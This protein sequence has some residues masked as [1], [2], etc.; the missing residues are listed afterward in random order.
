MDAVAGCCS[1]VVTTLSGT[2]YDDL[3]AENLTDLQVPL[4]IF[5]GEKKSAGNRKICIAVANPPWT[6]YFHLS[7][8]PLE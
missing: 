3:R 1:S 4:S 6:R 5:P 2:N 8:R 7:R